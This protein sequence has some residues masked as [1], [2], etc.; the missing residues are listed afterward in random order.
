MHGNSPVRSEY[1]LSSINEIDKSI[2][3]R[4]RTLLS[5]GT[6]ERIKEILADDN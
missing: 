4:D 6:V 1:I 5:N 2:H 3:T